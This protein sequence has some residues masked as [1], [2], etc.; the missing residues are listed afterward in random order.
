M[1]YLITTI[2]D[3]IKEINPEHAEKVQANLAP[4]GEA[5]LEK[6]EPF[7]AAYQAYLLRNDETL[8]Y[9]VNCY[10]KMVEDMVH[11]R[12]A[13]L[14]SGNYSN[15]SFTAVEEKVYANP[16]VMTYHMHGLVLAQFL[17]FD[18]FERIAFFT[19]NLP[20]HFAGKE[21]YLE[22]GGGHGLY[23]KSAMDLLPESTRFDMVDISKSSL[24]LAQGI[25]NDQRP[26][27]YLKNVFEFE[28][29]IQYDFI[30]I[31][32]VIEH[33]EEPLSLL[34]KIA[35]MMKTTSVCY[36][37]TPINAP[38]IDHIYLFREASEIRSLLDQAGFSIVSEIIELS[39]RT[40]EKRARKLKIPVMYAAFIKKK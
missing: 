40:S 30:T 17:W 32:E 24:A 21:S 15:T 3:K 9:G 8:D 23:L 4:L 5:V 18:Q 34:E 27:Y 22:I 13:F 14:K 20:T 1:S 37:T 31:G 2:L 10:L 7:F 28:E 39:E 38:M 33:V 6:S 35:S 12:Y 25:I 29:D 11:E 16:Q 36:I 26:N 19:S